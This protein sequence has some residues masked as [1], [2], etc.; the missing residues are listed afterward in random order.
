MNLYYAELGNSGHYI[1]EDQIELYT[2]LGYAV[3]KL[4]PKP[5]NA[6]AKQINQ[7]NPNG[8]IVATAESTPTEE[9]KTYEI[10]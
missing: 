9:P 6:E 5:L 7:E 2:Q 3:F 10:K 8:P 1:Q 4:D